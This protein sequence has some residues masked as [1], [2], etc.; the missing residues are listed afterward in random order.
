MRTINVISLKI[1]FMM[2]QWYSFS[3]CGHCKKAKPEFEEAADEVKDDPKMAFAAVDC[4]KHSSLCQTIGV[5]GYP[6]IKYFNYYNKEPSS[7]YSGGRKVIW[8]ITYFWVMYINWG[9][10]SYTSTSKHLFILS[11][12]YPLNQNITIS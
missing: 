4:T 9:C 11:T 3:G 2:F 8:I 10:I 6:T 1:F 12:V 7:D 5:S